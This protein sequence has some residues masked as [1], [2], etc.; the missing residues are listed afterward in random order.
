MALLNSLVGI[1]ALVITAVIVVIVAA[2][3][4]DIVRWLRNPEQQSGIQQ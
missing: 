3:V 4:V 1:I 2:I